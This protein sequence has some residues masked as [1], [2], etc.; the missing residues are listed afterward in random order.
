[1]KIATRL[2]RSYCCWCL[3]PTIRGATSHARCR[4]IVEAGRFSQGQ[5]ELGKYVAEA[6]LARVAP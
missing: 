6:V 1:M 5:R 4:R 3:L 2:S